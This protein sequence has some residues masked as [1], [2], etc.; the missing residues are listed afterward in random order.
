MTEQIQAKT[1]QV[2]TA[3]GLEAK[4]CSA[5]RYWIFQARLSVTSLV[6]DSEALNS[7]A[8]NS[9]NTPAFIISLEDYNRLTGSS[10]TLEEDEIL[11]YTTKA[12]Y[13]G[14]TLDIEGYGSA[15]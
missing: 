11:L 5:I 3:F 1:G 9:N 4:M 2:L 8:S 12:G 6:F 13:S 10:E 14:D 7:L 15:Y